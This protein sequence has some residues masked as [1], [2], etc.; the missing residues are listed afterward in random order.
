M[1]W[2]SSTPTS[3][4]RRSSPRREVPSV[5]DVAVAGAPVLRGGQGR[6]EDRLLRGPAVGGH[7]VPCHPVRRDFP[8][9]GDRSGG[10]GRAADRAHLG[11][12]AAR[13]AGAPGGGAGRP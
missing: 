12:G 10:G 1:I 7:D 6:R 11:G 5:P 13:A 4:S 2:W 9:A 3:S 8:A